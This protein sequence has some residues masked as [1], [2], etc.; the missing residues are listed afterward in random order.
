MTFIHLCYILGHGH[1]GY[2]TFERRDGVAAF[3]L[4]LLQA[5][6][7]SRFSSHSRPALCCIALSML[8]DYS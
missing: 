1:E 4:E 8:F 2:M 7:L 3:E 5:R 6:P